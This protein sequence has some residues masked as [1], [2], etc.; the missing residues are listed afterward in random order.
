[1]WLFVIGWFLD[2]SGVGV[3]FHPGMCEG[4]ELHHRLD[5]VVG[6]RKTSWWEVSSS[7]PMNEL[8]K[9]FS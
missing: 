6:S 8:Q 3:W 9:K 7:K 2:P 5:W 4:Q 1:M